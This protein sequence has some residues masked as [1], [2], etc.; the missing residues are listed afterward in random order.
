M[1][2]LL[3]NHAEWLTS[4]KLDPETA[5]KHGLHSRGPSIAIPYTVDGV[6]LYVKTRNP[7]DKKATRIIAAQGQSQIEQRH[8]WNVDC[9]KDDPQPLDL[10]V[11]TE[12]ELDALAVLQAGFQYVVSLPSGAASEAKGAMSKALRV[13]EHPTL[14]TED[15]KPLILPEVAKFSRVVIATDND[16]DGRVMRDALGALITEQFS[17]YPTYPSGAKD[18]NEVLELYGVDGVRD[19]IEKSEPAESDGY[20]PFLTASNVS[21]QIEIGIPALTKH[22]KFSIPEFCVIGGQTSHGKSTVTQNIMFSLLWTNPSLK[23]AY[24][25]GEGERAVPQQRIKKFWKR[26]AKPMHMG[27]TE[28]AER[29]KWIGERMWFISPPTGVVPTFDWLMR[30]MEKQARYR[31]ANV[32]VV[33][34]WN[35]IDMGVTPSHKS[36]TDHVGDCIIRMK[37]LAREL[38]LIMI[39]TH[40]V[41]KP[42][43]RDKAPDRYDLADSAH[44]ANKPDHV[45][46]VYRPVKERN[47]TMLDV[48]K[49]RDHERFGEPGTAWVTLQ[50]EG[51]EMASVEDP[52]MREQRQRDIDQQAK[53]LAEQ[54]GRT[55]P[56]PSQPRRSNGHGHDLIAEG[57]PF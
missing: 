19:L 14:K 9:L 15:G 11:I 53:K 36:R 22:M 32:F 48:Q 57:A 43:E 13:L 46:M 34:P 45:L 7:N 12:G 44:W 38:G 42:R 50:A 25:Y 56:P 47:E 2:G 35:E 20:V 49:S 33:D 55:A 52:K 3:D 51:F 24:F 29:D 27:K 54:A 39:I 1:T 5:A 23:A 26:M 18:A 37:N 30:A 8:F 6:T 31:G 4:R 28:Q 16:L 17:W 40:H 10:L 41:A 21:R